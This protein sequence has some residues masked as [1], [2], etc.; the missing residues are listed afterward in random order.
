MFS[1]VSWIHPT[2]ATKHQQFVAT[3][4]ILITCDGA[5][6]YTHIWKYEEMCI[7]KYEEMRIWKMKKLSVIIQRVLSFKY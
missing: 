4:N 5:L 7:W 1:L 6:S 2:K 3:R